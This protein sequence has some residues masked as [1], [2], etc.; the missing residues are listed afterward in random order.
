M[1][2][3]KRPMKIPTPEELEAE[4]TRALEERIYEVMF[5]VVRQMRDSPT[6]TARVR[7][8][9]EV[10]KTVAQ[11][12]REKGWRCNITEGGARDDGKTSELVVA[13]SCP[14]CSGYGSFIDERGI[15]DGRRDTC[16]RCNGK[17]H[18]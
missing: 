18:L 17:G 12:F 2:A 11:S 4:R 10:L 14:A 5:D 3:A 13:R 15:G 16:S 1:N 9:P 6:Y 8:V 7:E